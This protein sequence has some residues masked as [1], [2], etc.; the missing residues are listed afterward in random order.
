MVRCIIANQLHTS[1]VWQILCRRYSLQ[2]PRGPRNR[3]AVCVEMLNSLLKMGY[4][5]SHCQ[6]DSQAS[7]LISLLFFKLFSSELLILLLPSLLFYANE[8]FLPNIEIS[9]KPLQYKSFQW[10]YPLFKSK[11]ICQSENNN[12]T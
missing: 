11:K 3:P 8:S 9:L 2:C 6:L 5:W 7:P 12:A 10:L 4:I 1:T